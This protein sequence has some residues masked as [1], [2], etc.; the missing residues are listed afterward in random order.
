MKAVGFAE[1]SAVAPTAL[2]SNIQFNLLLTQT[3]T[4]LNIKG[5]KGF[6]PIINYY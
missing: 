6:K 2:L 5:L 4:I 3:Y 1:G